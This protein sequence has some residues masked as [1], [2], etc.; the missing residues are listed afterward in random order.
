[1]WLLVE[2]S[3]GLA[4]GNVA[5]APAE[6]SAAAPAGI[7]AA[8]P[9][10][11][12]AAAPTRNTDAAPTE[13]IDAAPA[14]NTVAAPAGSF[15]ITNALRKPRPQGLEVGLVKPSGP[16]VGNEKL[17][18]RFVGQPME[19]EQASRKALQQ[20]W[21]SLMNVELD[22]K[23]QWWECKLCPYWSKPACQVVRWTV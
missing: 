19:L 2:W 18:V 12:T 22:G 5:A 7:T 16:R 9:A 4:A 14:R 21:T 20:K 23:I 17:G 11:N 8:A 13:N 15:C 6:N 1:M 3:V 10:G